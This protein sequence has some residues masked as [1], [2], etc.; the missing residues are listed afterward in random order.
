MASVCQHY[1][2]VF[3]LDIGPTQYEKLRFWVEERDMPS[4]VVCEALSDAA[5]KNKRLGYA[6]GTLR[7]WKSEGV[8]TAEAAKAARIGKAR[9]S[10]DEH[11]GIS[12]YNVKRLLAG[13]E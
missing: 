1:R 10:P 13:A 8:Q 11:A 2:S 5:E 12:D 7:N 3:D 4:E 9:A 6:E